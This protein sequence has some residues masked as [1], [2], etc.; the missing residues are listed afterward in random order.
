MPAFTAPE[1]PGVYRMRLKID[2]NNLDPAGQ[3]NGGYTSN[4]INDNGGYIFDFLLKV[5]DPTAISS[6]TTT[7]TQA[8]AFDLSGRRVSTPAQGQVVIV[9]GKKVV[10]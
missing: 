5:V 1:T 9:N 6:S 4:F 2:W 10:K 3:F 8:P 7:T